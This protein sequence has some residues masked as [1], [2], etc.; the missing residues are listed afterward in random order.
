MCV[1]IIFVTFYLSWKRFVLTSGIENVKYSKTD[2]YL[3]KV[4]III[5]EYLY[6]VGTYILYVCKM[7]QP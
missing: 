2:K 7:C 4:V 5:Q 1:Y 6:Y 3:F